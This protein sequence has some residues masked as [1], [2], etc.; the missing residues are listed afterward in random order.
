M[1]WGLK[2][3]QQTGDIHFIAFSCY[4]RDSLL[5]KTQARDTFVAT[6]EKV[7]R[8]YATYVIGFCGHARTRASAVERTRAWEPGP[9]SANA[10]A[11]SVGGW[12]TLSRSF[13]SRGCPV[14]AC[15][16]GVSSTPKRTA[17]PP[18]SPQTGDCRFPIWNR[19][20][21]QPLCS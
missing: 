6:L 11:R 2:R 17:I 15:L 3:Y 4:R 1:P 13:Y 19:S 7:R 18:F 16:G 8:W 14:Q 12:P 20:A 5:A 9:S 21:T 10:Q